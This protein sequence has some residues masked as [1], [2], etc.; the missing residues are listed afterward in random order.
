MNNGMNGKVCLITG[1]S[2]GIGQAA[3]LGLAQQGATVVVVARDRTRGAAAVAD[4]VA[5]SRNP[6]V[7]LVLADLSSQQA[8]RQLAATVEQ[9]YPRLDVLINNAGGVFSQRQI[10][11]DGIEWTFAV[12]HLAPFLLTNLLLDLLL[13]SA[14]ARIVTVS[15]GA[16]G[17]GVINF[18]D[19]QGSARYSAF[20]S[21]SQSKLANVLF[22]YELARRLD[23]TQVTANCLHPGVVRTG[24]GKNNQGI[25]R[26]A[27]SLAAPFLRSPEQGAETVTYL[28]SSPDVAGVTGGY[29]YNSKPAQSSN[30]S[31][32]PQI[33]KQLWDVSAQMTGLVDTAVPHRAAPAS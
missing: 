6:A 20:R 31:H 22:T 13:V 25:V 29:F 7:E 4:I 3:A 9:R 19:L 18:D 16:Q 14:P 15:S 24:F 8:V 2:S 33:A 10:T 27:V 23:P 26:T 11:Q 12:N 28:A 5:R 30:T 1:A 32:D 17:I 21:Y